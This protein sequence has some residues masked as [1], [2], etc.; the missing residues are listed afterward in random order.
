METLTRQF[1]LHTQRYGLVRQ[2]DHLLLAVSGGIDSMT[3]LELFCRVQQELRLTLSVAHVNHQLRGSESDADEAFVR[4]AAARKNITF[5]SARV[6]TLGLVHEA[7]ISKQVAARQLRYKFLESTRQSI[8]AASIATAHHANDNAETVMMN[9][10]RGAGIRGLA[11]IPV[12]NSHRSLIRPLLY[13]YRTEIKAFALQEG[14]Q[15]RE[16]SSNATDQ[17]R[18]N[19]LR[20]VSIPEL[21]KN[22]D[23]AIQS[24]LNALSSSFR[25]LHSMVARSIQEVFPSI[26]RESASGEFSVH[27]SLLNR[28]PEFLR[29]ELMLELFRHIGLEPSSSKVHAVLELASKQAG[30]TLELSK[31]WRA[32]SDRGRI[33]FHQPISNIDFSRPLMLGGRVTND[34]FEI[35][36]SSPLLYKEMESVGAPDSVF[37]DADRLAADLTIRPWRAGDS[38]VPAGLHHHKKISD[39]FVDR[40]VPRWQKSTIPL[41]ESSGRIVWVCGLRLD[42][43]FSVSQKTTSVVKLT[44]HTY[45]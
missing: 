19:Y 8:D 20:H 39:F 12:H 18:R 23:P 33:V 22:F 29:A 21:E 4:D 44:Y 36:A 2:G 9:A 16:D 27:T 32:V 13:L 7:G 26:M 30:R 43:R 38:F 10:F 37:V 1:I 41:V 45:V 34:L 14:I 24:T 42:E 25:S 5:Y 11:G 6:D 17:Y 35:A 28:Q 15:F 31:R 3:M 40:K